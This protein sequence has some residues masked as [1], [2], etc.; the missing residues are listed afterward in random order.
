MWLSLDRR[1][2]SRGEEV[3]IDNSERGLDMRTAPGFR[4][5]RRQVSDGSDRIALTKGVS[6]SGPY[7]A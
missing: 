1:G 3:D 7:R 6:L 4:G 5:S 2:T